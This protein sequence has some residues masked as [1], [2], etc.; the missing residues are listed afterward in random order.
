[1]TA[2]KKT[3]WSE[4]EIDILKSN[5][6]LSNKELAKLFP[7]RTYCSVQSARNQH[8]LRMVR[9][10][11]MCESSFVSRYSNTKVCESCNPS[12]KHDAS[13]PMVRYAHYKEGAAARG[14]P[15]DLSGKE[16]WSLWQKPC[17]YCGSEINTI[18]LDRIDSTKGYS[19]ENVT[20]CCARCNEMKM[21]DGLND[22]LSHMKKVLKHME[23]N[24]G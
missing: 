17:T 4:E 5:N 2:V 24:H 15:F 20:P 11:F 18:G 16:F 22:W 7:T 9:T 14:L 6:H 13:S 19:I 3:P 23:N 12:G 10:C 21:A 8:G 1:M